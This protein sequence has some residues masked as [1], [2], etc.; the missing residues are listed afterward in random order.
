V[1]DGHHPIDLA[2]SIGRDN[3]YSTANQELPAALWLYSAFKQGHCCQRSQADIVAIEKEARNKR[4]CDS[5]RDIPA[6]FFPCLNHED[7][8]AATGH[9]V[10]TLIARRN[11]D[12]LLAG[13]RY[14]SIYVNHR[15]WLLR[16][17]IFHSGSRQIIDFILPGQIFG[18]QSCVFK[19]ALYSV[20]TITETLLSEIPFDII[21]AIFERSHSLAKALF[22]SAAA[23]SAIVGEHLID[24][25]RRSAYERVAHLLLELFV[26]LKSTGQVNGMS[27]EIPLTQE[28]IGDA[29]GL[30][31]VHVNRTMRALREDKLIAI[32][33]QQVTILDFEGLSQVSDFDNSYL[34]AAARAIAT[35]ISGKSLTSKGSGRLSNRSPLR[36]PP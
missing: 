26:R 34:G 16:Y 10:R 18:I 21:D 30:T 31:T 15:G 9:S 27:F 14:R 2:H 4:P 3:A 20:T 36:N 25:A 7:L 35:E 1:F 33:R 19:S 29:V 12:L 11:T 23:E 32:T 6:E 28:L 17:K 8:I 5:S 24:A 13:K 22:L